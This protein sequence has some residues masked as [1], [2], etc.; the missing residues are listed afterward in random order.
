MFAIKEYHPQGLKPNLTKQL[1]TL[2]PFRPLGLLRPLL[3]QQL[4]QIQL[5]HAR[6]QIHVLDRHERRLVPELVAHVADDDDRRGEIVLKKV[7]HVVGHAL[8]A[9]AHGREAG[10]ELSD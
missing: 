8:V 6:M 4:P 9:I 10:P 5:A 7:A 3:R 1:I 2:L